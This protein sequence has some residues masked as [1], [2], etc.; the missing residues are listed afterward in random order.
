MDLEKLKKYF[1]IVVLLLFAGFKTFHL[2]LPY[3]WDEA[4]SYFPA[5]FKM[6]QNGPGMLPG[7]LSID[8]A[9]GHPLFFFFLSSLWMSLHPGSIVFMRLLPLLISVGI[10]FYAWYFVKKISGLDAANLA[11]ALLAVQSLFLAQA[12]F[13]LPEMLLALLLLVSLDMFLSGKF[14]GYALASSLMI[15]TKE[16]AIVFILFFP[17]WHFFANFDLKR[18]KPVYSRDL[19]ALLI[20]IIIYLG[21]LILHYLKFGSFF[22]SEHIGYI[23]L[24][25]LEILTK[26]K[27]AAGMVFT[28]Y[29]R[30]VVTFFLLA[31]VAYLIAK[32]RKIENLKLLVLFIALT[33]LFFAFSSVNFYT[34]RYMLG[35]MVLFVVTSAIIIPQARSKYRLLNFGL[36]AMLV[37]IPLG[38]SLTH[39]KCADSDLGFVE[40]VKVHQEMV[41]EC[42]KN[43]WQ[44]D[45]ISCSFNMIF[46]LRDN[47]LG[48]LKGTQ[49][50][51]NVEDRKNFR[52]AKVFITEATG[53]ESEETMN[54]V[55]EHFT[56]YQ[57]YEKKHAWGEIYISQQPN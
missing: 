17:A 46:N 5:I 16:T 32:G 45:T 23:K 12:T 40:V 51:N 10:L 25:K 28:T 54:Y 26:L 24:E 21:Y 38:Y 11:I 36:A 33:V 47:R 48:Y 29:G 44:N 35:I 39:K 18:K 1:F 27:I 13:L 22:Y 8:E 52:T 3:F 53:P 34:Q 2:S 37:G 7:A 49:P 56:L 15:M 50:F 55:R 20:P 30:V 9:K 4:W 31:A 41:A 19:L 14:I 57:R 6:Y 42:E 43:Q